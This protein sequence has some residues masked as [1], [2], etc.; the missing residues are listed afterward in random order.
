[1]IDTTTWMDSFFWTVKSL[2][3]MVKEQMKRTFKVDRFTEMDI[4]SQ[5]KIIFRQALPINTIHSIGSIPMI[6]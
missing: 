4:L 6:V 5:H 2:R 1:M 3:E